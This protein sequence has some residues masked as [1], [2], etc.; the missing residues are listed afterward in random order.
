M[1]EETSTRSVPTGALVAA[2][3]FEA[4]A[5]YQQL[6]QSRVPLEDADAAFSTPDPAGRLP[7]VHPARSAAARA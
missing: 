4:P 2:A 6:T 3:A 7:I 5:A 1:A